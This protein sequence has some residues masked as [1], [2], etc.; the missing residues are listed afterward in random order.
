MNIRAH[1]GVL[2][3]HAKRSSVHLGKI[4]LLSL[5]CLWSAAPVSAADA[6][7]HRIVAITFDDL[8]FAASNASVASD[9]TTAQKVH[10]DIL[11]ALEKHQA[12][13]TM[14]VNEAAVQRLAPLSRELLADWN[15]GRYALANHGFSHADAN[16]LD[17]DGID[18]EIASGE[19][20]IGPMASMAGRRL[21]FFRFPMNHIGETDEK[22]EAI[23]ALLA[24][25]GYT[26]AAS[27]IDT[28]DYIFDAAYGV[29]LER[30]DLEAL[31]WLEDAYL[32]HSRVQIAYYAA[33]NRRVIG[34]DV[35]AIMLL[36]LNRL[37]AATLDRLLA[38][39]REAGYRFVS[40]SEAQADPIYADPPKY[41]TKFGPMWGYRWARERGIRI[42]GRLEPVPPEWISRYADAVR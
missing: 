37:N 41:S 24:R 23:E 35:P 39:F 16:A 40:L 15:R 9:P 3:P 22:R 42:D 21:E 31:R 19:A 1:F 5:A 30:A 32:A 12:P 6:G 17:L 8:P 20:T 10:I 13:A 4:C 33:L 34:R 18:Q 7:Q 38:V 36:H 29:A 25:R 28:S 14:F 11:S 26:L 2:T 27:T